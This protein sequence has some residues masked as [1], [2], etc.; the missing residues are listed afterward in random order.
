MNN[1][2]KEKFRLS[3]E[4]LFQEQDIIGVW[5][6]YR[7]SLVHFKD[8]LSIENQS[9]EELSGHN[10]TFFCT[11]DFLTLVL[12]SGK[13]ILALFNKVRCLSCC[14]SF[15]FNQGL[16][17]ENYYFLFRKRDQLYFSKILH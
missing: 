11:S 8:L 13:D 15:C 4:K 5:K 12:V 14:F 6:P 17:T 9:T 7:E 16:A 1:N 10:K 3:G 2:R